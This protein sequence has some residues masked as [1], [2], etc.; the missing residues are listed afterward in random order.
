VVGDRR[1]VRRR[2]GLVF[3]ETTADGLLTVE[4]NLLARAPGRAP[5]GDGARAAS[6]AIERAGLAAPRQ[7][8]REPQGLAPPG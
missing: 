1:A 3:Q 8:A 7:Q 4:E 6:D 5:A 2:L